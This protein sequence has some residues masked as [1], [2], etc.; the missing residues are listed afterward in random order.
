M[1]QSGAAGSHPGQCHGCHCWQVMSTLDNMALTL[2]IM[3][4]MTVQDVCAGDEGVAGV[5][6][7]SSLISGL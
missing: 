3:P 2:L 5:V 4:M 1:S 7:I 6:N